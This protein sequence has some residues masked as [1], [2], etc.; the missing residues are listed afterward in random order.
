MKIVLFLIVVFYLLQ[1]TIGAQK[2][3][4]MRLQKKREPT[5]SRPTLQDLFMRI[6][7]NNEKNSRLGAHDDACMRLKDL[8]LNKMTSSI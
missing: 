7:R 2:D 1:V 6:Y 3:A 4:S 8:I 5:T